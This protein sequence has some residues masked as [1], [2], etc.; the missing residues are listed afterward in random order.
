VRKDRV[1]MIDGQLYPLHVAISSTLENPLL[2]RRKWRSRRVIRPRTPSSVRICAAVLDLA[3]WRLW[4]AFQ[5]T[6]GLD[7]AGIDFGLSDT[8]DLLLFEGQ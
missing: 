7:Y 2:H 8:G 4:P 1:M 5:A 6:L 3:R